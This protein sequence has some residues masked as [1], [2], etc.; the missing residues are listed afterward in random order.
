GSP[1][2]FDPPKRLVTSGVYRYIANPMQLSYVLVLLAWG[3]LLRNTFVAAGA[4]VGIVYGVGLAGWDERA[5]LDARFGAAW[6]R[7]R[8]AVRAWGIR[9]KP[10]HDPA[11]PVA[12]LYVAETYGHCSEVRRWIEARKPIG[13]IVLAAEDH[14]VRELERISYDPGDGTGDELG[15]A[16]FA[17]ALEHLNLAWAAVGFILRLPIIHQF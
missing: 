5:D 10:W 15:I 16:A 6:R 14:P 17:R 13:L 2:P 4:V 11:Q 12:R 9:W 3:L 7:Y 8:A 1:I